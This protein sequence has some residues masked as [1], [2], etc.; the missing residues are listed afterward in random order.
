MS[1]YP[2]RIRSFFPPVLKSSHKEERE[3]NKFRRS[4]IRTILQFV[5]CTVCGKHVSM[6]NGWV[7]H[8]M[9]WGAY[10]EE[11][12][13]SKRCLEGKIVKTIGKTK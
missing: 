8:S 5:K 1:I 6:R 10:C 11:A 12:W 13:C 3:D 4:T 7:F 2:V 9:P